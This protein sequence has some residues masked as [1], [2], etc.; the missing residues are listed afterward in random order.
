[1][2]DYYE[3]KSRIEDYKKA[4]KI[5]ALLEFGKTNI[6][7]LPE[8]SLEAYQEAKQQAIQLN[9]KFNEAEVTLGICHYRF[10]K[11]DFDKSD[12]LCLDALNILRNN[13]SKDEAWKRCNCK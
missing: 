2:K 9:D 3:L 10:V 5:A 11:E 12:Q 4:D 7:E 6:T 8:A 13:S 1:M